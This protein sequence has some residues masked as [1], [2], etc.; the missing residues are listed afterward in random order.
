M[1][2][3]QVQ[4]LTSTFVPSAIDEEKI[5]VVHKQ[6]KLNHVTSDR[7]I[8]RREHSVLGKQIQGLQ[9]ECTR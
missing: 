3:F 4:S 2:L 8:L 7:H 5:S 6:G 1:P 9:H